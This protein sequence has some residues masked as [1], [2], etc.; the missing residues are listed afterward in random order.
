MKNIHPSELSEP[1]LSDGDKLMIPTAPHSNSQANFQQTLAGVT[2]MY[3]ERPLDL[4]TLAQLI[5]KTARM[6]DRKSVV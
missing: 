6:G 5:I 1:T 4:N 3:S 2:S